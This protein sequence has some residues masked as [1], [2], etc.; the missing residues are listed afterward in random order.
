MAT[1]EIIAYWL[2]PAERAR[3]QCAALIKDLAARFDAPIFEAHVTIYVN[4]AERENPAAVLKKVL[5]EYGH[6]RLV[7]DRLDYSEKFTKTLFVQFAPNTQLERVTEDFRRASTSPSDYELNPHLSLIYKEMTT[8]MKRQLATSIVL[9]FEE[10]MFDTVKA[11]ISPGEI[12]SRKDV[13]A[14]RVVAE[15]KLGK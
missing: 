1:E 13:E 10:A 6:F 8:E 3:G 15:A 14:W 4:S 5:K 9:P 2:C 12:Q 7:V 11:I